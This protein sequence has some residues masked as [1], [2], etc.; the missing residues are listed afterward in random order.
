MD[1]L[2]TAAAQRGAKQIRLKTYPANV[3]ALALYQ[4]MGYVF[5][6]EQAGQLTGVLTLPPEGRSG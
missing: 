5:Q 3:R 4:K 1:Y 6:G 2:H